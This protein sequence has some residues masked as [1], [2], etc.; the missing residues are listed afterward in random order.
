MSPGTWLVPALPVFEPALSRAAELAL[1]GGGTLTP[2]DASPRDG[3][4]TDLFREA[5]TAARVEEW[6]E[7]VADC[8]KFEDEIAKEIAKEKFSLVELEEEEQ[9]LE[10]LRRWYRELKSRDVLHVPQADEAASRLSQCSEI[11]DGY[12]A[13]VYAVVLP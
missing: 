2:V 9:S 5:F 4:G 11:L 12:A 8:G 7:F 1:R 13:R 6:T 10:R 3:A